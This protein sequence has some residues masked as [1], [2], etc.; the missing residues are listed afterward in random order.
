MIYGAGVNQIKD[1]NDCPFFIHSGGRQPVLP[2]AY[3]EAK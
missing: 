3:K 2:P 1:S